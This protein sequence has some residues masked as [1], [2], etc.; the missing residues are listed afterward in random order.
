MHVSWAFAG[1]NGGLMLPR[2]F[3]S[4]LGAKTGYRQTSALFRLGAKQY[5]KGKGRGNQQS[6]QSQKE[7]AK[8]K[9]TRKPRQSVAIETTSSI[10]YLWH[11]WKIK[12]RS[13]LKEVSL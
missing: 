3:R 10:Y 13:G 2:L 4:R 5:R 9:P 12:A 1:M 11:H 6:S 8:K 7:K